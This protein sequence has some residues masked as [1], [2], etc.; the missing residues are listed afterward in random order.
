MRTAWISDGGVV[1]YAISAPR[2][3]QVPTLKSYKLFSPATVPQR[4]PHGVSEGAVVAY[5]LSASRCVQAPTLKSYKFFRLQP[6]RN[7]YRMEFPASERR[8]LLPLHPHHEAC[9]FRP[10]SRTS[11]FACNR[12]AMRTAWNIR[13]MNVVPSTS[14][15]RATSYR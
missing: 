12:T 7:E 4:V 8:T 10:S 3:V 13:R 14:S 6:H 9:K 11:S 2:C 15:R 1:A 5:A